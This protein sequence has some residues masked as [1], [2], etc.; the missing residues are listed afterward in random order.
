MIYR[1]R[2]ESVPYEE[3]SDEAK[4]LARGSLIDEQDMAAWD[5]DRDWSEEAPETRRLFLF[6]AYYASFLL[7]GELFPHSYPQALVIG[8]GRFSIDPETETRASVLDPTSVRVALEFIQSLSKE[9]MVRKHGDLVLQ[10]NGGPA[11][12]GAQAVLAGALGVFDTLEAFYER[13]VANG[14]AVISVL[15]YP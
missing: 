7:A 5:E 14:H 2:M 6:E 4:A 9:E 11:D 3:V 15:D 8:G 13:V 12:Q 1:L 10:Q